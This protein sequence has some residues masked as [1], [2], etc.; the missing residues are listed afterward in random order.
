M[1]G[2]RRRR[3]RPP[4]AGPPR[5][6]RR[7]RRLTVPG[8]ASSGRKGGPVGAAIVPGIRSFA[9]WRRAAK[10]SGPPYS[11][12]GTVAQ[13][14]WGECP[15]SWYH[16][17]DRPGS[18]QPA[19]RQAR[20]R[21]KREES[22]AMDHLEPK[23]TDRRTFLQAGALATA[24]AL[25]LTAAARPAQDEPADA[26]AATPPSPDATGQ[27]RRRDHDAG[28]GG[29]PRLQLRPHPP[30]RLRQRHPHLRRRQGLRHRAEPPALVRAGARRSASRSSSITKDMPRTPVADASACS[31]SGW[32][33]WA[34]TTSTCSS[35]TAWAT[36]TR[37]DDAINMVT[38]QEFKE[39]AEAIRK[40]GKAKFV[41]FSSHH[42]DRAHD[43]PGGGRGRASSTRSCS[44]TPPGWT[45]TR[46]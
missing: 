40:S 22:R 32:R 13:N 1:V 35:S 7:D 10:R 28:P 12:P 18:D 30:V 6:A 11:G 21:M 41:G 29:H 39:T 15:G 20:P 31:T 43:H 42:K 24:S 46:R 9:Q 19:G 34:P 36:T 17:R 25:A 16:P 37:L 4:P 38:S 45:R 33:R 14:S 2:P 5:F 27:D 26:G 3:P 23:G 44:S 8:A